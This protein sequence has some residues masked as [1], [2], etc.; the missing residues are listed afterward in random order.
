MD[1]GGGVL[2]IT[3]VLGGPHPLRQLGEASARQAC[4]S[5]RNK[6]K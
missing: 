5:S 1:K 4:A 3:N 6:S 2:I